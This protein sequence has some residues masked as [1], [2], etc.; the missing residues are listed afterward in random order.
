MHIYGIESLLT[1]GYRCKVSLCHAEN[2]RPE[3][4]HTHEFIELVYILSGEGTHMISNTQYKVSRGDLL[5]INYKQ[6]HSFSTPNIMT[7]VNI[8]LAPE[9]ISEELLTS[10][11]AFALLSLSA[12]NE[13]REKC[14]RNRSL[15]YFEGEE[16]DEIESLINCLRKECDDNKIGSETILRAGFT[17]LLTYVFRKL[18]AMSTSRDESKDDF[19]VFEY[20]KNHLTE[21]ITLEALAKQS[22]YNPSYFSRMFKEKCGM[23]LT[24]Y[25]RKSRLERACTLLRENSIP[26]SD[27]A[28]LSGFSTPSAFHKQF[29]EA[30]G[31][32][33]HQWRKT[34]GKK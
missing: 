20:I 21:P 19:P 9:F 25:L 15:I 28:E 32:T 1:N 17:M 27:I 10:E 12:F 24:S 33:P 29:K 34:E 4:P 31:V 13:F 6:P 2:N 7:H 26:I 30:Y 11:N 5:F 22:F 8:L 14:D 18:S 3:P 23:T 16:R